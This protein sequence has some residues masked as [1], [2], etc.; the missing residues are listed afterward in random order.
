[1]AK[2]HDRK[3]KPCNLEFLKD[4]KNSVPHV[5]LRQYI[6]EHHTHLDIDTIDVYMKSGWKAD[7]DTGRVKLWATRKAPLAYTVRTKAELLIFLNAE[8]WEKANDLQRRY[9][10]DSALAEIAQKL[11]KDGEQVEDDDGHL[12]WRILKPTIQTF[13]QIIERH[14]FVTEDLQRLARSAVKADLEAMPLFAY[15]DAHGPQADSGVAADPEE[16]DGDEEDT[17][18]ESKQAASSAA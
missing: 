12:Q 3:D 13:P 9:I 18:V 7:A 15:L 5:Y 8:L 2:N 17:E 11:D 14:G 6:E 16:G 10:I 4:S 1:M